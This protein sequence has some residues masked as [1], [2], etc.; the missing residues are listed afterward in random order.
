M[1]IRPTDRDL[2]AHLAMRYVVGS[3]LKYGREGTVLEEGVLAA[4]K[5]LEVIEHR[6][7]NT[8]RKK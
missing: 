8:A 6:L 2:V 1:P 5:L 4:Q 3:L 7:P